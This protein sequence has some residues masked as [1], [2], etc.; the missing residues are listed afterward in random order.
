MAQSASCAAE[1][2][3][4]SAGGQHGLRVANWYRGY[5]RDGLR[6]IAAR[7]THFEAGYLEIDT[8]DWPEPADLLG[9]MD[10]LVKPIGPLLD[11]LEQAGC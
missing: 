9:I 6:R 3:R 7:C 4:G 5:I 8:P 10:W 2:H 1:V 11:E